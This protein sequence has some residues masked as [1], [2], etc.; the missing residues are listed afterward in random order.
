MADKILMNK[1][2][3]AALKTELEG[4]RNALPVFE[5]KELQLKGIV[6]ALEQGISILKKDI[7]QTNEQ[8]KSWVAVMAEERIDL[9]N[10]VKVDRVITEQQ[11]IAGVPVDTFIDIHYKTPELDY[12]TTPLWVDAAIEAV[13]DQKTKLTILEIEQKKLE[14]LQEELAEARRMKNALKEVFIPEAI[15]FIRKI[16]IYLGDVERLAI[17]CA[18]L[19]KKKKEKKATA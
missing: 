14:L 11:E 12:F 8:I 17:G 1:N 18:K 6:Q 9:S 7:E 13:T 5:M 19:V 4:Y 3:L 2:S 15:E 10:L 16:E